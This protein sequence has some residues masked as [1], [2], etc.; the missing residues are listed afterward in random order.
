MAELSQISELK[1]FVMEQLV[2]LWRRKFLALAIC[3]GICLVGWVSVVLLPRQYE[4]NARVFVDVNGFLT[5]L[6]KGMVVDTSKG[7]GEDYLRQTLLSRPNL[8]K[9]IVLANLETANLGRRGR[10][11]LIDSLASS[12]KIKQE[13]KNLVGI[14]FE[15]SSPAKARNVVNALLTIFAEAASSSNRIEM[16]KARKFLDGQLSKYAAQL[17]AAEQ[18]RADFTR[19]YSDYLPDPTSG[20]PRI[21]FLQRQVDQYQE[22]Y[23][24]AV[25]TRDALAAQV[26]AAPQLLTVNVPPVAG[27]D[28]KLIAATP[29]LR[30]AQAKR[31][32]AELR[33]QYTDNHPD[34][35]SAMR[36]V[37]ELQSRLHSK[38]MDG[39]SQISNPVYE[40][41]RLKLVDA[42]TALPAAKQRL[43]DAQTQLAKVKAMSSRIPEIE[44][45][46]KD[47]D[48]DYDVIKAN[49][50]ELAKRR[51][52]ASLS[53]AAD[54]QADR[55]Q[56]RIVDPPN[57]PL[58]PSFPNFPI[59]I[60]AVLLLGLGLGAGVPLGLAA[61]R[62]TF[63]SMTRLRELGLPVIGNVTVIR[64]LSTGGTIVE[65]PTAAVLGFGVL[66][67]LY[68]IVIAVGLGLHR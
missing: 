65:R 44:A 31:S 32:L 5:P 23:N 60:S 14:S 29:E 61:L 20:A 34:V 45:K 66:I 63:S 67:A 55:T 46:G 22:E 6:L 30:L 50:D 64:R 15:G 56:F 12:A 1:L 4:S 33:L 9:V 36:D 35:Q 62:P 41:I 25:V 43:A 28:G 21:Q 38:D 18:R 2:L 59:M 49:Y 37:S 19:E 11:E 52:S 48:R 40:Q 51:E 57:L 58:S 13:S 7:Q 10:E 42:E 68:G 27:P 54:D 24:R 53:Q 47:I 26:K 39:K 3:W 16:E 17:R 8:A